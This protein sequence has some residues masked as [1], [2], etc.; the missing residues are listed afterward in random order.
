MAASARSAT[1]IRDHLWRGRTE[2][3]VELT[4]DLIASLQAGAPTLPP[5]YETVAETAPGAA[6]RLLEY[7]KQNRADIVDYNRARRNGQRISTAAAESAMNHVIN[8][9]MSK[10]QQM[11]WSIS[12]ARCPLQTRVALLDDRLVTH[13]HAQFRHFRSP[14]VQCV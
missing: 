3:A 9:R 1:K 4:R 12:G 5:F 8:R 6:T 10:G 14:E 2:E 7:V 13:F 11:R